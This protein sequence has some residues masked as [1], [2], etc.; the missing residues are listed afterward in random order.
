MNIQISLLVVLFFTFGHG[1]HAQYNLPKAEVLVKNGIKVIHITKT[2]LRKENAKGKV[3]LDGS[4]DKTPGLLRSF[5]VNP[6]GRIDSMHQ[7]YA[8]TSS[9]NRHIF[10]FGLNNELL[11]IKIINPKLEVINR[12]LLERTSNNQFHQLQWN[13]GILTSDLKATA[14]SIIYENTWVQS[15]NPIKYYTITTYNLEQDYQTKIT[16][17]DEKEVKKQTY[18][19]LANNGIPYAFIYS[20]NTLGDENN[21]PISVTRKY[22]VAKDGSVESENKG[23]FTDPFY[24]FNYF[25]RHIRYTGIKHPFKSLLRASTL[26][27]HQ[28]SSEIYDFDGNSIVYQY[29]ISYK[30]NK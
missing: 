25:K 29:T 16:Y 21:K 13:S 20:K 1:L 8:D 22:G 17:A 4:L 3:I 23:L 11:E 10:R 9:F 19:W 2:A 26:I 12:T 7:Y 24:S 6:F 14:D 5:F 30:I 18:Q 15:F 28:E 27:T